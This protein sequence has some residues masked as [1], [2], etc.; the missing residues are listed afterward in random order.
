MNAK[1]ASYHIDEKVRVVRFPDQWSED[2]YNFWYIEY[3]EGWMFSMEE[4]LTM[5]EGGNIPQMV[6]LIA[7]DELI[8]RGLIE[9]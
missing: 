6:F 9:G 3:R 5:A 7:R 1:N 2:Y 8:E 4:R